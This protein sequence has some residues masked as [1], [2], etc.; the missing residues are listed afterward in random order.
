M[1]QYKYRDIQKPNGW[2][3]VTLN[4]DNVPLDARFADLARQKNS[5]RGIGDRVNLQRLRAVSVNQDFLGEIC[6][7]VNLEYL[8]IDGALTAEDLS[9]LSNL[10]KLSMLKIYGV[11]KATEF[12]VLLKLPR[13]RRLFI[14]N[15]KHVHSLEFLHE[16][17]HLVSLGVE[18]SMWTRQ[19]IDS[20]KPLSGLSGLEALFLTSVQLAHKDLACLA[21]IP[22]LKV[23]ECARFAPRKEFARLRELMPELDC[24]WCDQYDIIAP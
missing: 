4:V 1:V 22:N 9:P 16:A 10:T 20:L 8:D 18:G 2:P 14:E 3:G 13:L 12:D 5:H 15:A 23:L 11:R 17:H 6:R 7:L 19:K 21:S 24:H